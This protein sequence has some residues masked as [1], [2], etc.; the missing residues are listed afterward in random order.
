MRSPELAL[1]LRAARPVASAELRHRVLA[2]SSRAEPVRP[3]RFALPRRRF[4]LV[5]VPAV[6]ALA[7]GGAVVQG[8]VSSGSSGGN[9][10]V[11]HLHRSVAPAARGAAHGELAS[12]AQASKLP[13]DLPS[14][15]PSVTGRLQ[16][17]AAS[18]RVQVE[19]RR[20]LS[21]ATKR[22]MRVTRLLGGYVAS[23]QYDAP[24]EG[25]GSAWIVVRIPVD[26][27]QDAVEEYSALG[28]LLAQKVAIAD[29]TNAVEEQAKEIARLRADIARL[30]RGGVTRGERGRHAAE[31]VR[32]DYLT[33]RK[34]ATVR[35]A[36][37]ARVSLALTTKPK[38]RESAAPASRFHRTMSDAGG[39]LLREG[40]I[41]LYAL[42]VVGPLLLLGA[43]AIGAVRLGQRRR[44]AQLLE[45][46]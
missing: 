10:S 21:D 30:E 4:A 35:R 36:Q 2:V 16:Q 39:V 23:A 18:L 45:R 41:L 42:I 33:K 8:L 40:E 43:A 22:A 17:Y 37:F 1:E 13:E 19:T 31:K 28:T 12:P 11:S 34:A 27:V 5:A 7:V 24:R 46:S 25:K 32:L 9:A 38:P 3:P 20:Q 15:L 6:L 26:R 29:V 14:A 44:D